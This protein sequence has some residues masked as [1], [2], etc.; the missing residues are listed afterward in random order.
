MPDN[1]VHFI[2]IGLK[3]VENF[4]DNLKRRERGKKTHAV[5]YLQKFIE[6]H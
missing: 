4:L 2:L 6:S 3:I 1:A 5:S